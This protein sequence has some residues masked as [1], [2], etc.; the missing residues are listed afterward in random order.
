MA[1]SMQNCG[2]VKTDDQHAKPCPFSVITPGHRLRFD[3]ATS[4]RMWTG[5]SAL[6]YA[7]PLD[8]FDI[9]LTLQ[10]LFHAV[11]I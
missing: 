4:D 5:A 3:N 9:Q 7:R 2:M 10:F 6:L 11:T 8:P 1:E